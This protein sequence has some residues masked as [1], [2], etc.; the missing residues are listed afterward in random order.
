[1]GSWGDVS[2]QHLL[3]YPNKTNCK[4]KNQEPTLTS[5]EQRE[6]KPKNSKVW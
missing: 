1:M 3:S 4:D 5:W 6:H 2:N